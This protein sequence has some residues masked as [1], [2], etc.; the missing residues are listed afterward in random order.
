MHLTNAL[1]FILDE[2]AI[3]VF[4]CTLTFMN[5]LTNTEGGTFQVYTLG[6]TNH[7]YSL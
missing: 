5:I 1:H 4:S 6:R 7:L 2:N 3:S